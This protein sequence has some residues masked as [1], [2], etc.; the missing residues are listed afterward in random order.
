MRILATFATFIQ[1]TVGV[2]EFY[3]QA[4]LLTIF[5][6]VHSQT[7]SAT[8]GFGSREAAR[9]K[10]LDEEVYSHRQEARE[11]LESIS[12]VRIQSLR[13]L[14]VAPHSE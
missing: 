14:P 8:R 1:Q 11:V 13:V 10:L 9:C 3:R 2:G 4:I 12:N 5:L 6:F 7:I